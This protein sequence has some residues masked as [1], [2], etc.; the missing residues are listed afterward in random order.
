[1]N[2]SPLSELLIKFVS[3]SNAFKTTTTFLDKKNLKNNSS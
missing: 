3:S 1:M 2:N